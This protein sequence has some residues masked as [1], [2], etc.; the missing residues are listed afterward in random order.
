MVATFLL[1]VVILVSTSLIA[2][3][4]S[5]GEGVHAVALLPSSSLIK[6]IL[7]ALPP[8]VLL[9]I[10]IYP[11]LAVALVVNLNSYLVHPSLVEIPVLPGATS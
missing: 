4:A 5:L 11:V 8:P 6:V 9:S 10:L 7:T 2:E 1:V 3:S